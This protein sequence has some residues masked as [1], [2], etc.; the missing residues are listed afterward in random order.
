MAVLPCLQT[1][2]HLLLWSPAEL[3]DE[4]EP[5]DKVEPCRRLPLPPHCHPPALKHDRPA[6]RLLPEIH[7]HP[8]VPK[9]LP[10]LDPVRAPHP[11]CVVG[12]LEASGSGEEGA[13][14]IWVEVEDSGGGGGGVVIDGEEGG[15]GGEVFGPNFP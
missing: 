9:R 14:V 5:N 4:P 1:I 15:L 7:P 11:N 10:C 8:Y 13:V 6:L 3:E 12:D 2:S